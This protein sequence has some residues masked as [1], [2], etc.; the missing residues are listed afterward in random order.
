MLKLWLLLQVYWRMLMP[1]IYF[2]ALLAGTY[3]FRQYCNLKILN[4]KIF[5][6]I[7]LNNALGLVLY[8]FG[9]LLFYITHIYFILTQLKVE[10]DGTFLLS[11]TRNYKLVKCVGTFVRKYSSTPV[12]HINCSLTIQDWHSC[13][14]TMF[15]RYQ[16]EIWM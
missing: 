12:S 14:C 4:I 3:S 6:Y 16:V 9:L 15:V 13:T 7:F 10:S 2:T 5:G 11:L 1:M 8:N